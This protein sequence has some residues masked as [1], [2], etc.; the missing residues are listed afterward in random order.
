MD[1]NRSLAIS[2]GAFYNLFISGE[3]TLAMWAIALFHLR[4]EARLEVV[5]AEDFGRGLLPVRLTPA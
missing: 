1:P 4:Q 5:L 2:P 3:D